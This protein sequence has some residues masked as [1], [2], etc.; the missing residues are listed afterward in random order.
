MKDMAIRPEMMDGQ[1]KLITD[2]TV[3]DVEASHW[4]LLEAPEEL[5][6]HIDEWLSNVVLGGKL[7]L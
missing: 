2:L 1:D 5:Y 6:K 4:A 7:K 3:R